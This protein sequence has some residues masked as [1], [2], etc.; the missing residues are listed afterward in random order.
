MFL[1]LDDR[2]AYGANARNRYIAGHGKSRG[3]RYVEENT[4]NLGKTNFIRKKNERKKNC[5]TRI[6]RFQN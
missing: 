5:Y 2:V 6:I 3:K 4:E 1:P